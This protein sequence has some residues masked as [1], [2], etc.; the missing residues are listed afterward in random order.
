MYSGVSRN[1]VRGGGGF[2]QIQ[3]RTENRNLGAVAPQS[4][5]LETAIIWYKKFHFNLLDF[6]Y[7]KTIYDD[8]Q[9]IYHC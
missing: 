6:W 5:V 1:L 4:G 9:F 7:F 3:L 8:N 2:Q